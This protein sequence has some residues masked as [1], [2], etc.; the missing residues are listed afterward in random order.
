MQL[1][2]TQ[3]KTL[4]FWVGENGNLKGV[5]LLGRHPPCFLFLR[6]VAHYSNSGTEIEVQ[7]HSRSLRS[8]TFSSLTTSVSVSQRVR[9]YFEKLPPILQARFIPQCTNYVFPKCMSFARCNF[10]MFVFHC[11]SYKEGVGFKN[12]QFSKKKGL[13]NFWLGAIFCCFL[14]SVSA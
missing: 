4:C 6:N 12:S 8:N 14:I 2:S 9:G 3:M 11:I 10:H 1:F 7:R 13:V 5:T